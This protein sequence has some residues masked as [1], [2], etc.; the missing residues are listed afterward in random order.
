M[1]TMST[2]RVLVILLT[3]WA[4]YFLLGFLICPVVHTGPHDWFQLPGLTIE[5]YYDHGLRVDD[6]RPLTL[7]I[8]LIVCYGITWYLFRIA[9]KYGKYAA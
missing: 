4:L 6:I 9:A 7:V 8:A 2:M 1:K 3:S 5:H